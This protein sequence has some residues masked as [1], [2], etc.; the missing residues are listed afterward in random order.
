MAKNLAERL[1]S[2]SGYRQ[3]FTAGDPR[4]GLNPVNYAHAIVTVGGRRYHVLSRVCDAGLDYTQRSNKLAHHVALEREEAAAAPEGPAWVLAAPGFCETSWKGSPQILP[5]GRL[6]TADRRPAAVCTAWQEATGDAGW[7]GVLAEAGEAGRTQSVIFAAGTELLPLVVEALSLLPPEKRWEVTFSTYFTK[8]A[9]GTDCHWRFLLDGTPEAEALR[10]NPHTLLID[11]CR[12]L[13]PAEGGPLVDAARTSLVPQFRRSERA[14]RLSSTTAMP[15]T[16]RHA[17]GGTSPPL[18]SESLEYQTEV[19]SVPE[20]MRLPAGGRSLDEAFSRKP[21][22]Q[23]VKKAAI[24]AL[25]LL[26]LAGGM[27]GA[28]YF[29]QQ[30]VR[31]PMPTLVAGSSEPKPS[32][33]H[34]AEPPVNSEPEAE[35]ESKPV[36]S[37]PPTEPTKPVEPEKSEPMQSVAE[38][39]AAAPAPVEESHRPLD[40]VRVRSQVFELP[41]RNFGVPQSTGSASPIDLAKILAPSANIC[42]LTLL[43]D[44]VVLPDGYEFLLVP[45]DES[46]GCRNWSISLKSP[47]AVSGAPKVAGFTLKNGRFRFQWDKNDQPSGQNL[48]FCLLRIKIG[49]DEAT[50]FLSKPKSLPP[51]K[52]VLKG[53]EQ[54]VPLNLPPLQ[55]SQLQFDLTLS[56]FPDH[57]LVSGTGP[58]GEP[59]HTIQILT[60]NASS[61]GERYVEI[62]ISVAG[63]SVHRELKFKPAAYGKTINQKHQIVDGEWELTRGAL[64]DASKPWHGLKRKAQKFIM[65]PPSDAAAVQ[66]QIDGLRSELKDAQEKKQQPRVDAIQREIALVENLRDIIKFIDEGEQRL[67]QMA[68]LIDELEKNAV[69]NLRL[70][71]TIGDTQV[72]ILETKP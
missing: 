29:G 24:A 30:S 27:F 33:Q 57:K 28:F 61:P 48:R 70:F 11:L 42:E 39:S 15:L 50:C 46:D 53:K 44:K 52:L 25:L 2:L 34:K 14:A 18:E 31:R 47:N 17:S 1:E 20:S 40:D 7:A 3:A 9:A 12:E 36:E 26:I 23:W 60:P 56:G 68:M 41:E 54:K 19:Q 66:R 72:T 63:D 65:N 5:L 49:E 59:R 13:P 71:I 10:R 45:K 69:V 4:A 37:E 35:P 6:P 16:P 67:K 22:L 62:E 58:Q 32:T 21:R 8:L 51:M 55:L 64:A 38:L 43:G